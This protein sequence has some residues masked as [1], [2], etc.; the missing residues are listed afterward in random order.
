MGQKC[1]CLFNKENDSTYNFYPESTFNQEFK[2]SNVKSINHIENSSTERFTQLVHSNKEFTNK[3]LQIE[4]EKPVEKEDSLLN[5]KANLHLLIKLQSCCK[6][7]INKK[8]FKSKYKSLKDKQ[9]REKNKFLE[10]FTTNNTKNAID[11]M[12][13]F[14][15]N[16]LKCL[17]DEYLNQLSE[18][19]KK[20]VFDIMKNFVNLDKY[21]IKG[22]NISYTPRN[23]SID[24]VFYQEI[25]LEKGLM[26]SGFINLKKQ[27]HGYGKCWK[28]TG[29]VYEG[30]WLNNNFTGYGRYITEEGNVLE[31]KLT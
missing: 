12:K 2:D 11:I 28:N 14:P 24:K 22:A 26:Y 20:E 13:D 15:F 23:K 5:I 19:Q 1:S 21:I 29:E 17:S 18:N 4:I 8:K 27:K 10:N 25:L 6:S 3:E 31:G 16:P 7:F 9:L 30:Y